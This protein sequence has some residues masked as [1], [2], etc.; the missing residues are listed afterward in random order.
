ME[1][2]TPSD[3]TF[4]RTSDR[5]KAVMSII[6][7]ITN[8]PSSNAHKEIMFLRL[9]EMLKAERKSLS[10]D[11]NADQSSKNENIRLS[12]IVARHIKTLQTE[13][14]ERAKKSSQANQTERTTS[15]QERDINTPKN[16]AP[17]KKQFS[18]KIGKFIS[19]IV[20]SITS[21]YQAGK[22]QVEAAHTH[23]QPYLENNAEGAKKLYIKFRNRAQDSL[24]DHIDAARKGVKNA[25]FYARYKYK[26]IKSDADSLIE[27]LN[28][29]QKILA[30][31]VIPA[32]AAIVIAPAI[33]MSSN[34][35]PSNRMTSPIDEFNTL[36]K[37]LPITVKKAE[38]KI[39][40]Q[41]PIPAPVKDIIQQTPKPDTIKV[42][43]HTVASS[44]LAP[45]PRK[46]GR[47]RVHINYT[48]LL[49][50]PEYRDL[51]VQAAHKMIHEYSAEEVYQGIIMTESGGKQFD[52]AG[53][54]LRSSA[55]AI[56]KAQMLP[57]TAETI[58]NDCTG[59]PV[60]WNK[61]YYNEQY[62]YDLG[63]CYFKAMRETYGNNILAGLAYNGGPGGLEW[64]MRRNGYSPTNDPH[65]TV[66]FM[67]NIRNM[68]NREY[69]AQTMVKLG[70]ID[71]SKL[72][73]DVLTERVTTYSDTTQ[74]KYTVKKPVRGNSITDNDRPS[75][76]E[77]Q[78]SGQFRASQRA[79][80]TE[81]P[82]RAS[83][84]SSNTAPSVHIN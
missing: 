24:A 12:L 81:T 55:N 15:S 22:K 76:A 80:L 31:T 67:G 58:A 78:I 68:E 2:T 46:F 10:A 59:K 49:R 27:R 48:A 7:D 41:T 19:R 70:L 40:A 74:Y 84:A 25:T 35:V 56:G 57:S 82:S 18:E 50:N 69:I 43:R 72:G 20:N 53:K 5:A 33:L 21:T 30:A 64:R 77:S 32:A 29:T 4:A 8:N 6:S 63:Y 11:P 16:N 34:D 23:V 39:A 37:P 14:Q 60:I 36:S 83:R 26:E 75:R 79:S 17:N 73:P 13:R 54:P 62:N 52:S 38:Q 28:R 1:R 42:E 66:E 71:L 47:G 45:K 65:K 61:F 3:P 51:L 9:H 44:E